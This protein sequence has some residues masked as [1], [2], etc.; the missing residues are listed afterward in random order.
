MMKFTDEVSQWPGEG[1]AAR[2][3]SPFTVQRNLKTFGVYQAK[4]RASAWPGSGS[5]MKASPTRKAHTPAPRKRD[6]SAE[7]KMPLSVTS[8][9]PGGILGSMF[10]VVSSET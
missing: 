5:R 2:H 7:V 4:I 6:T 8:K 3:T 10:R 9:R 1:R